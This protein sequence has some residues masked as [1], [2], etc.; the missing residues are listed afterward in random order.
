MNTLYIFATS[1]RPDAYINTVAYTIEHRGVGKIYVIVISEHNY[2]EEM[3]ESEL[4]AST[5]VANIS[6]Q[7]RRLSVGEYIK[8]WVDSN[9]RDVI[10]LQNKF[11]LEVYKRSLEIMNRS[12]TVGIVIPLSNLDKMLR[13]YV[14]KGNCIIDVSA[15]KKNLLIDAVATLLSIEF[16]E[17]Y[18]FELKKR[19]SYDETDLY[20]NLRVNDDYIFRNL[21]IVQLTCIT[22]LGHISKV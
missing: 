9:N 10:S 4:L 6:E 3:Q 7:L 20:H 5:V 17:V 15:L 2:A 11:N 16:S 8:K 21:A 18:S 22:H 19:P 12:G 13:G 14:S 1:E